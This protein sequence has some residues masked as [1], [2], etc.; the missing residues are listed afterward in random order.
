GTRYVTGQVHRKKHVEPV[1]AVPGTVNLPLKQAAI[2]FVL[3]EK[4]VS[5]VIPGMKTISHVEDHLRVVELPQ[6][7]A[8]DVN[9]LQELYSGDE[10]LQ[11][12][13]FRN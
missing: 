10:L 5:V 4:A 13:F 3:Y 1:P 9:R 7:A 2:E 12:G 11:S 8:E 6:L